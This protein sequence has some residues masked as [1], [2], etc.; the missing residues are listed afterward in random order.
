MLRLGRTQVTSFIAACSLLLMVLQ[1]PLASEAIS[2]SASAKKCLSKTYGAKVASSIASAKKLNSKQ[3]SQLNNCQ[4]V[5]DAKPAPQIPD[6]GL[7]CNSIGEIFTF[8]GNSIVC[9]LNA[10]GKTVWSLPEQNKQQQNNPQQQ[11][12]TPPQIGAA[13][14]KLGEIVGS[15]P[16]SLVCQL[17]ASGK[18]VWAVPSSLQPGNPTQPSQ[19]GSTTSSPIPN[20]AL[21][22]NAPF[23]DL[24]YGLLSKVNSDK[25]NLGNIA[26]PSL[27]EL[28]D[29]SL[30]LF[31]KSGNEPQA[32][33]TGIQPKIRSLKSSDGG[34][35]W[36]LEEGNRIDSTDA[37]ISV[38]RAE[39]GGYEAFGFN[40]LD[41]K[42]LRFTSTDGKDF[43]KSSESVID[44]SA[45][46]TKAGKSSTSLG[47]DPQVVKVD[48][49]YIGYVKSSSMTNAPP[50]TK[51]ACKLVSSD[52]VNW[53]IDASGT[54]EID[55]GSVSSNL[56]LFKDKS[57]TLELYTPTFRENLSSFAGVLEIRTSSDGGKTWSLPTSRGLEAPDAER[58]DLTG[59]DSLLVT[60][61]FDARAGGTILVLKKL[62]SKYSASRSNWA[63][64]SIWKITGAT[65]ED[66]KIKNFCLNLDL[67][68]S[69]LFDSSGSTLSVYF[70]DKNPVSDP[71]LRSM[72]CVY[73]VIGP[74]QVLS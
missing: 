41:N 50:W 31:F 55:G 8:N 32:G 23:F 47:N 10:S 11:P 5:K 36:T 20:Y 15:G 22:A 37:I 65:K 18:A 62:A 64:S 68:S 43:K 21:Q 61:G 42:L 25:A 27:L 12:S 72:S 28:Q 9:A 59:G 30:R 19:S 54:I 13:C 40:G 17:D 52:G 48:S 66:V 4:K 29:G 44:P 53:S 16:A 46:K 60:G 71:S 34:K 56:G 63:E 38:R 6:V 3:L 58:I 69:A 14:V 39:S 45:C 26:D 7:E 33:I 35:N 57:G 2:L 73:A 49:G 74:E 24:V 1:P 51:V 70:E 67:T